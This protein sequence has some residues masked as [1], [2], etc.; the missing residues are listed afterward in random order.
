MLRKRH[1]D[2]RILRVYSR[3]LE[4]KAHPCPGSILQEYKQDYTCPPYAE[5]YALHSIIRSGITPAS[6]A[7]L[8][9]EQ[10]LASLPK[11]SVL[12][13]EAN[14]MLKM[15][16]QSAERAVLQQQFDIIFCTCNETS[17][18]R[19]PKPRQV[20]IDEAGMAY[21]PE[22]LMPICRCDHVVLLGDHKQLQP[23][24]EHKPAKE[25]G[26]SVSL[27]ERYAGPTFTTTLTIQYRMVSCIIYSA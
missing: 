20:I 10:N 5:R 23:V 27:F 19:I 4:R 15:A 18:S 22:S 3:G 21:E 24:I 13:A 8:Q 16:I 1:V 17:S 25:K 11:H 6:R 12:S 9:L 7:L 26:L 2:L 14:K